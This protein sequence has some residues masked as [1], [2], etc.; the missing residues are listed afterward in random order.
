MN[1]CHCVH[2]FASDFQKSLTFYRDA[3]GRFIFFDVTDEMPRLGA[4]NLPSS[5]GWGD[6]PQ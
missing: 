3:F 1:H 6:V 4:T 5:H 2:L